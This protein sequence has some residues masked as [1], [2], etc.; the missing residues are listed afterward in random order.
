GDRVQL[1]QVVLNLLLNAFDAVAERRG[2]DGPREVVL[3]TARRDSEVEVAVADNGPGIDEQHLK[4]LFE[5]FFTT[6]RTGWGMGPATCRWSVETPG[7]TVRATNNAGG[8]GGTVAF[9]LPMPARLL[10][11][12]PHHHP[13]THV[14]RDMTMEQPVAGVRHIDQ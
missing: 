2:S 8:R 4:R 7:G 11:H 6:K 12:E 5:P 9:S 14:L 3:R 1:Q 10:D 13:S